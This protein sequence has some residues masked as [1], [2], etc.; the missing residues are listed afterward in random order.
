MS[1]L[2]SL[3]RHVR[4]RCSPRRGRNC[5]RVFGNIHGW[6]G[7]TVIRKTENVIAEILSPGERTQ[8]RAVVHH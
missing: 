4:C 5:S 3:T 1:E 8:V 2:T 7:R 6:I